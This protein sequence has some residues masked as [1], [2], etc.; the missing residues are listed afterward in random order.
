MKQ[1]EHWMEGRICRRP[2]CKVILSIYNDNEFCS[3]HRRQRLVKE[4][5]PEKTGPE[6]IK[7]GK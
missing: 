5:R 6:T 2:G 1:V 4:A 3:V 7:E